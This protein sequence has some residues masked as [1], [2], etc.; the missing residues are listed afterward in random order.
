M[1]AIS[2]LSYLV[3][4]TRPD[5]HVSAPQAPKVLVAPIAKH[6]VA[7]KIKGKFFL[8][9]EYEGLTCILD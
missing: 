9:A 4:H 1:S 6:D 2:S 3:G 5:M 7:V 8:S